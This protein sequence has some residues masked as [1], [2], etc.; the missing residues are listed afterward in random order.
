MTFSTKVLFVNFLLF[1]TIYLK[2][3]RL[4]FASSPRPLDRIL[5]IKLTL[6]MVSNGVE[7][8]STRLVRIESEPADL[9]SEEI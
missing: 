6:R 1:A 3:V 5:W 2:K 7:W 9:S 8:S 4:Y